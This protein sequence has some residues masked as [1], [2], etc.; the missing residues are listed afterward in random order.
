MT[1]KEM[2]ARVGMSRTSIRFY[3]TEGLI[4]PSRKDNGYRDYSEADAQVLQRVK[5]LRSMDVSLEEVKA[6]ADGSLSL[7]AALDRL[8]ERLEQQELARE[9]SRK[10]ARLMQ[11]EQETF[12]TLNPE[13]YLPMLD[14]EEGPWQ[15]D[16]KPALNLPW[17]R[18]WARQLDWLACTVLIAPLFARLVM[19]L[20][21]DWKF[22][23]APLSLVA[24]LLLEPLCLS[25]FATTP[26]KLIFG[27]RVTD[28]DGKRLSYDAAMERTWG[29]LWEGMALYIP[30]LSQYFQYRSLSDVEDGETLPWE[31]ESELTFKDDKL[32]RYLPLIAIYGAVYAQRIQQILGGG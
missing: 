8:E 24:M 29:V 11:Q 26:G 19:H 17:R 3:E 27:I 14:A 15:G 30:L 21:T 12:E 16:G 7:T 9:R 22:G 25:L 20:G 1:I 32:W 4:Q 5:L 28:P 10:T 23:Y 6:L 31:W 2:E 18:Y 13:R